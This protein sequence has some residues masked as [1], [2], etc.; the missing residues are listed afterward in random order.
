LLQDARLHVFV[1]PPVEIEPDS[2]GPGQASPHT[3]TFSDAVT[4]ADAPLEQGENALY[5]ESVD[6]QSPKN[7]LG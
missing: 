1:R 6:P 7:L 4:I 2:S 5:R 3:V